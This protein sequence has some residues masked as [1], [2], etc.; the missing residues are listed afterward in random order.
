MKDLLPYIVN[1]CVASKTRH[2]VHLFDS[3]TVMI[4][5]WLRND[6]YV[7][8]I[9]GETI[10]LSLIDKNAPPFDLIP[11]RIFKERDKFIATFE[12]IFYYET[13]EK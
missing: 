5:I 4:D 12:E 1:R 6:F 3:G 9:D 11:D 2:E 13:E 7:I 10:G 8:Q